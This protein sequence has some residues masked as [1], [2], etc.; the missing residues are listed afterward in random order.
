[1]KRTGKEKPDSTN[2]EQYP[3]KTLHQRHSS[4]HVH[5]TS[6][7]TRSPISARRR[8]AA[9]LGFATSRPLISG[10]GQQKSGANCAIHLGGGSADSSATPNYT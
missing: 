10:G 6:T 1:M 4:N 8:N 5:A 3:C 9:G 2:R 7:S